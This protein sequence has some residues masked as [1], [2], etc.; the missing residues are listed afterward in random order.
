MAVHARALTPAPTTPMST[1]FLSVLLQTTRTLLATRIM[2]AGL[3]VVVTLVAA[4]SD[5]PTAPVA[6]I[7]RVAAAR[8][9]PSV[10]DARVRLAPSILNT[11]VRERVVHDLQ[12][13]ETALANGDAQKARF[14]TSLVASLLVDY[15][16][17]QASV[18]SD[19]ADISAIG[20]MVNAVSLVI[21]DSSA[22]PAF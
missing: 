20:L 21:G 8:V 12:E 17:Q 16:K 7:D 6:G 19:G 9:M 10:T 13:L 2:R 3:V 22:P 14:H 5:A 1:R 4:C 18:L 11:A 15:R